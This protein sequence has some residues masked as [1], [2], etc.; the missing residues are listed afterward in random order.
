[1]T[2]S[3][4]DKNLLSVAIMAHPSRMK[5]IGDLKKQLKD[6]KVHLDQGM[7]VWDTG[8]RAW[9]SYNHDAVWHLVIQDDAILCADFISKASAALSA[10]DAVRPVSFYLGDVR[11]HPEIVEPALD[12]VREIGLPWLEMEGPWWGVAIALP[13][14]LIPKMLEWCDAVTETKRYDRRIAWYFA[15]QQIR[16]WYTCPSL[17]DHRTGDETPSL[18]HPDAPTRKARWFIDEEHLSTDWNKAALIIK[19]S[20]TYP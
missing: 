14:A 2:F 18:C 13:T 5:F 19:T 17:V 12:M 15:K 8:A 10:A 1:M 11:P 6:A 3:K 16:C 20:V 4:Q 7:G 9:R